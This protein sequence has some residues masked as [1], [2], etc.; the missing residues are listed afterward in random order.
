MQRDAC[1]AHVRLEPFT[2]SLCPQTIP[3]KKYTPS[4]PASVLRVCNSVVYT[5]SAV[6][7]VDNKM[8][9]ILCIKKNI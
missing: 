2:Y 4:T 3:S 1:M 5:P 6:I 7:R 9:I 8:F